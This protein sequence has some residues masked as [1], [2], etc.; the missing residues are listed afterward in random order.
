MTSRRLTSLLL[1]AVAVLAASCGD[2]DDGTAPP[3][4]P[5]STLTAGSSASPTASTSPTT[6]TAGPA[7][8]APAGAAP[9]TT[10]APATTAPAS[11]AAPPPTEPLGDPEVEFREL[12]ALEQ[13]VD[14]T[15]RAGDDGLY[16]AEQPGR[17]TR[18]GRD[19]EARA[20]LDVTDLTDSSGEQGLLSVVFSPDGAWGYVH[21]NDDNGDTVIAALLVD[22][23]GAFD[24]G[25]M[26]VVYTT[27]QPYANHN[28]GDLEFGPDGM[29]YIALGDGGAGGDPERRATNLSSPL[30][31]LLRIDP[32]PA[33]ASPYRIPPDNPY[34]DAPDAVPE[35]WSSGLRNP[36]RFSFD[37]ATGDLWIADVGQNE[38]EEIDVAPATDGVGAG[39]GW[40]FGWSAF[41]GESRYNDDVPAEG[42]TAPIFT[43]GRDA[44]CSISGG[45]R[46]RGDAIPALA[47]WFVY[48]DYCSGE[49]WALDVEGEGTSIAAGSVVSL[50]NVTSATAVEAG[51]DGELYVLS[52]DGPVYLVEPA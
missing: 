45:A 44:G 42:H 48:A 49:V 1:L 38:F 35:I 8:T 19:G 36:W 50:G 37:P 13:P 41:E 27:D 12:A 31:K 18:I 3:T 21:Y 11:T 9:T 2:D 17:V 52:R 43:Y 33:A 20:V 29:L 51:A 15:W 34:A 28:G 30:G 4:A 10:G 16:V 24:G 32:T 47:G 40:S 5:A 14:L 22:A 26:V 6:P 7:T 25:S 23:D 39:R 46:Y